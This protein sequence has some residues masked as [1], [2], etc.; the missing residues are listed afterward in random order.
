[1]DKKMRKHVRIVSTI[2]M[3]LG[4][5]Y[6]LAAVGITVI[7]LM[8]TSNNQMQAENVAWLPAILTGGVILLPL[9]LVGVLHIVSAI[10]FRADKGWSRIS[11]WILSI[12]NLGNVPVGTGIAIYVI[13]VLIQTRVE[14]AAIPD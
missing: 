13:W 3:V 8:V 14:V 1:M 4:A 6:L 2:L 5:L 7:G 12:L 9:V 10:A 11:L